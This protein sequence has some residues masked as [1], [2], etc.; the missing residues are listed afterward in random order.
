MSMQPGSPSGSEDLM[1]SML[2]ST[3]AF[4]LLLVQPRA[5]TYPLKGSKGAIAADWEQYVYPIVWRLGRTT[6]G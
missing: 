1:S 6:L 4:I 5:V 2:K 3:S